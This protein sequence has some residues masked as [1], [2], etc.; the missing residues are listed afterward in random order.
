MVDSSYVSWLEAA[1]AIVVP[2]LFNQTQADTRAQFFKLSG[3][4]FTGGPDKPTDFDRYWSSLSTLYDLSMKYGQPL[5]GTCLGFQ[6]ISDLAA[7]GV[8]VL[9]DFNSV[10]SELPL[11][12]TPAAT[13][14]RM[15]GQAPADVLAALT[16]DNFTTNWHHY[17]VSPQTFSKY[18]EPAGF[19]AL[20]VN[21]DLDGLPFVASIEHAS[22]PV[23]ATQWHPE[24]NAYDRDHATVNHSPA[25]VHAMQYMAN[26]FVAEARRKGLGPGSVAGVSDTSRME[27]YPLKRD[28]AKWDDTPYAFNFVFE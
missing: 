27:N 18:V 20:S 24:A 5:W 8:D 19:R 28:M 13:E 25:A 6:A 22:Q 23:Y 17:G 15:F 26:F 7:G 4:L 11:V 21:V 10:E 1:G 12:F 2:I 9:G 14:S 16:T 3:V